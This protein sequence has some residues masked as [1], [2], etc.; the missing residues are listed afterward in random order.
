MSLVC[1]CPRPWPLLGL[2]ESQMKKIRIDFS[3]CT[4]CRFCEAACSLNHYQD[5]NPQH[6]RI[7]VMS[8]GGRHYP[9][10]AGP[11]T[12]ARC[13]SRGLVLIAGQPVETCLICR[14]S[15]PE[16]PVFRDG[17]G[18]P[19][20]CDFCGEPPNPSCVKWCRTGALTLVEV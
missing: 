17:T 14:A 4:G 18:A 3:K 15:C 19:L 2:L 6:S 7:R 12:Q 1:P 16:K 13:N 8:E 20:K 10:I 5:T 9:V 11:N